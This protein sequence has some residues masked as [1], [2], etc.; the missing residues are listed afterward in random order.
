ML[1]SAGTREDMIMDR[2]IKITLGLIVAV[3]VLTIAF[4]AYTGYVSNAYQST[5]VSSFSYTMSITT[6]SPLTNVTMF[7]PVPADS[8]GNS[9][10]VTQFSAQKM[11]G[12]PE[13]WQTALFDTGKATLVKIRIPSLVPPAGTTPQHPYTVT[14]ALHLPSE[15]TIDTADPVR[16]S[17]MFLPVNNL[18]KAPC[19]GYGTDKGI[20]PECSTYLTSIYADYDADPG[21]TVT[22]TSSITGK[23]SW[24]V[25]EPKS[26]EYTSDISLLLHGANH[27]WAT[28]RGTLANRIGSYDSPFHYP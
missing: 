24:T 17:P 28:V 3:L 10:A 18:Q 26:N 11:P 16:N 6:D 2:I 9:P 1:R 23:N 13:S 19:T 20:S 21:A 8:K 25:F 15:E 14:L 27:G 12:T 4:A 5:K 7:I 22:I